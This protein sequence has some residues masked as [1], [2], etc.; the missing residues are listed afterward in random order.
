VDS[1]LVM[2]D[3]DVFE[4]AD[5]HRLVFASFEDK[6]WRAFCDAFAD[7]FPD[8]ATALYDHRGART[9]AKSE[10]GTL[11]RSV[12]G[13]RDL[14]WW[15]PRLDELGLP[16]TPVLDTADR[17]LGDPSAVARDLFGADARTGGPQARF[18]TRFGL[19]LDTFRRPVPNL[20][21][22]SRELF[23][24]ITTSGTEKSA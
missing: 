1:E 13:Q 3:N 2:G 11:L 19:G 24:T 15:A 17:L 9:E 8:L 5:G 6:F 20:D 21:E 10:V 23:E 22:H 12:F 18:P 14:A 7:D 16:W 4:T